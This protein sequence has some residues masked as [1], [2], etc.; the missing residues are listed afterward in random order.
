LSFFI[1]NRQFL[2]HVKQIPEQRFQSIWQGLW[3][4]QLQPSGMPRIT[5]RFSRR[6]FFVLAALTLASL[7]RIKIKSSLDL[8][9]VG[10]RRDD[11]S[12]SEF[13]QVT[14]RQIHSPFGRD[15]A[16]Q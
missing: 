11:F 14:A 8:L 2:L 10:I 1:L 6:Y 4:L 7:S 3:F 9:A 15:R 5:P 12:A 13:P 16:A